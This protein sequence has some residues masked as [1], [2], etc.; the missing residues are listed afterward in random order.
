MCNSNS[1]VNKRFLTN[2]HLLERQY[3]QKTEEEKCREKGNILACQSSGGEENEK[4][5]EQDNHDLLIMFETL[6]KEQNTSFP[7]NPEMAM[8]WEMQ[9]DA[10]SKSDNKGQIRWNPL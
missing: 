9:K 8:F 2:E 4:I 5:A 6:K 10:I 7:D 1:K 3:D